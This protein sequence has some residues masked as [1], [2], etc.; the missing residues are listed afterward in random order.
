M[1]ES[2]IR[3]ILERLR[4]GEMDIEEAEKLVES[5]FYGDLGFANVDHHRSSRKG[6]PE[7][8]FGQNKST[9]QVVRI[10][11]EIVR[12]ES[13]VLATR[14]STEAL[15]AMSLRFPD[16]DR[17]DIARTWNHTC[18]FSGYIRYE[19]CGRSSCYHLCHE[20]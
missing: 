16:G 14:L 5:H 15:D 1:K 6:F 19:S 11:E 4:S 20:K 13:T 7:V 3:G 9:E 17:N 18:G 10:A 8:I 2:K 12:H